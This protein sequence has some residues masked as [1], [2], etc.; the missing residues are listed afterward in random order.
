MWLGSDKLLSMLSAFKIFLNCV[1]IK[2]ILPYGYQLNHRCCN[3]LSPETFS[4]CI[5][6]NTI[7]LP[8]ISIQYDRHDLSVTELCVIGYIREIRCS[9]TFETSFIVMICC[10]YITWNQNKHI[11]YTQM[12]QILRQYGIFIKTND[13]H[14]AN[15]IW[16]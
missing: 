10:T 5:T 9:S 14:T 4:K 13:L 7:T 8:S 1:N 2:L 11:D 16:I 6:T 12:T 3:A 15:E